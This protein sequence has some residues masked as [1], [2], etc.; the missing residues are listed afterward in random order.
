MRSLLIKLVDCQQLSDNIQSTYSYL[1]KNTGRNIRAYLVPQGEYV[2]SSFNLKLC[3][4]PI[5]QIFRRATTTGFPTLC[6]QLA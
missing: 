6:W 4:W 5:V 1:Q 2:Y 3:L